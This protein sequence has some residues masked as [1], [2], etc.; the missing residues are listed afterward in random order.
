MCRLTLALIFLAFTLAFTTTANAQEPEQ[1]GVGAVDEQPESLQSRMLGVWVLSGKPGAEIEPKPG[2]RLK[3]FALGH[4]AITECDS[5]TG[6]VIYH[7][8][9]TYTLEGD[10]YTEKLTYASKS[11]ETMIGSEFKFKISVENGKYT[12]IGDGNPFD[13]VWSR[14]AE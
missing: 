1:K 14:P 6:K 5:E 8:G 4:W 9:G 3:F 10:K 11:S 2:A 13:E 7:H 12:Q